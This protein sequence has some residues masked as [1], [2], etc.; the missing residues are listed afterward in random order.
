MYYKRRNQSVR[1]TYAEAWTGQA[2]VTKQTAS[3]AE[4]LLYGRGSHMDA[5]IGKYQGACTCASR[6]LTSDARSVYNE[7]GE[8]DKINCKTSCKECD[9]SNLM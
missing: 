6:T 5:V 3:M 7:C 9:G 4:L 2:E 8:W 1:G